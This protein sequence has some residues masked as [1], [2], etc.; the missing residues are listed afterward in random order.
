MLTA[1]ITLSRD[2]DGLLCLLERITRSMLTLSILFQESPHVQALQVSASHQY[3]L[4]QSHL[5]HCVISRLLKSHPRYRA[6]CRIPVDALIACQSGELCGMT[7]MMHFVV[8][9]KA[10][11]YAGCPCFSLVRNWLSLA[12]GRCLRC[13]RVRRL[14]VCHVIPT[15]CFPGH[16]R[17]LTY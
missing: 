3:L 5:V 15:T 9:I 7:C 13:Q 17:R 12:T 14:N 1:C 2:A 4:N 8:F 11:R 6:N 16:C 10:N